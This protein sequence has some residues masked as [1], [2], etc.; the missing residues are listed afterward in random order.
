MSEGLSKYEF[1]A[2][3]LRRFGHRV[4]KKPADFGDDPLS[5]LSDRRVIAELL[6]DYFA[7]QTEDRP[8]RQWHPLLRH[9]LSD[10]LS[11]SDIEIRASIRDQ[12][13]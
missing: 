8:W 12:E 13:Y 9:I 1:E 5:A 11:L 6:P 4:P 3:M 7:A 2:E 10:R